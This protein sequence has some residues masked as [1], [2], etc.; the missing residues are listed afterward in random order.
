MYFPTAIFSPSYDYSLSRELRSNEVLNWSSDQSIVTFMPNRKFIFDPETSCDGCDDKKDTFVT[1]NIPLL[2]SQLNV[3]LGLVLI[4]K[5]FQGQKKLFNNSV[6]VSNNG[7]L[8][9]MGLGSRFYLP[10]WGSAN[11]SQ[12][13]L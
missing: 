4:F 2:V 1:V 6:I 11:A 5:F 10:L 9:C 13:S 7:A 12:L 8:P 3:H